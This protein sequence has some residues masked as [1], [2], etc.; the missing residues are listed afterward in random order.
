M[1][2]HMWIKFNSHRTRWFVRLLLSKSLKNRTPM[3]SPILDTISYSSTDCNPG[4]STKYRNIARMF[5]LD[6]E[7]R[8]TDAPVRDEI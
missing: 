6:G 5:N 1:K 7:C 4:H 2:Y 3:G 8:L